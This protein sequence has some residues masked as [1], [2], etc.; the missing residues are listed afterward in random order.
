MKLEKLHTKYIARNIKY[1]N[2]LA[3][4]QTEAKN[5]A[6]GNIE[7]GTIVI[8]ENQISGKGTH[9]RTWESAKGQNATFTIILYPEC[10]IKKL[11]NITTEIANSI[12][13][14]IKKLYNINLE[15]K[16]P[17]D[18]I[19]NG[20]KI[21]GIL[22]EINTIGEVVKELFIGI[23]FNVKQ[24]EFSSELKNKATSLHL[25]NVKN[26]NVEDVVCEIC[27]ELEILIEKF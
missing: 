17:N 10:N 22:T 7:N 14:A 9:G 13:F 20:K 24:T 16:K 6:Q 18:L 25:N 23:G 12:C 19:L 8:T 15:I 27:N 26:A 11:E 4:T 3:S 21:G 2:I 5:L 1:Y